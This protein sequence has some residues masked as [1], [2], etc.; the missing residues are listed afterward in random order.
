MRLLVIVG[1]WGI[2]LGTRSERCLALGNFASHLMYSLDTLNP[3]RGTLIS[4]FSR[5]KRP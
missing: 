5:V 3:L 2:A 4:G 1:C